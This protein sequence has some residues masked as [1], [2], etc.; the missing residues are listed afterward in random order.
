MIL[1]TRYNLYR[2][3]CPNARS[4]A[5]AAK[6]LGT[7]KEYEPSNSSIQKETKSKFAQPVG[8]EFVY[9]Y[10]IGSI[11]ENDSSHI[12]WITTETITLYDDLI[13]TPQQT[14]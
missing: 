12:E 4:N 7:P 9:L 1:H 10:R 3:V 2:A 8:D 5:N 11:L 13:G 6:I 14:T